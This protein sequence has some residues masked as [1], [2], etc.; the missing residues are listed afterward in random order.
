MA[1]T[2][3]QTPVKFNVRVNQYRYSYADLLRIWH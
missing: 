2:A 3:D 1:M